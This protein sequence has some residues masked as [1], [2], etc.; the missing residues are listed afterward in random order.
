MSDTTR[1]EVVAH[2]AEIEETPGG[3]CG[4][5]IHLGQ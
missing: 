5:N 2:E 4:I 3:S 1:S